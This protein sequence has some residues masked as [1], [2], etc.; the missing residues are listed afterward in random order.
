MKII[1]TGATSFVGR[2]A[3]AEL[4]ARGHEVTAVIREHSTKRHLLEQDGRLPLG[5]TIVEKDLGRIGELAQ[6]EG[7]CDV[8]LHAGWH[9]AGSA[10]RKNREIQEAGVRDALTAMRTAKALGAKRFIFTG[11]QA[12]YGFR[13][14]LTDEQVPCHPTSAYGEAKL[15]VRD[16]GD[17]LCRE[18]GMDYVHTRIFSTYGPGDHPW[19]LLSGCIKT[20]R[21]DGLMEMTPCT[22]LWNFLYIDDAGRA[23]ADLAEYQ[24][25]LQSAGCVY[26]LAG[27]MEETNPLKDFVKELRAMIGSGTCCFGVHEYNAEGVVNLIPDITKMK[28]VVGWE[29]RV[30]FEEGIRRTIQSVPFR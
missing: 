29:P 24:G 30:S 27:S 9:G 25:S 15:Q 8:F 17:A 13:Q 16:R 20:F 4:L 14:E 5:L 6:E 10:D 28:R 3:V 22:Q 1:A 18:L 19:S 7:A 11:S 23:L 12:E 2:A 26:N 21:E